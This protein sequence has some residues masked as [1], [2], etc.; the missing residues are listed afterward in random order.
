MAT[1][2]GGA[3]PAL[4]QGGARPYRGLFGGGVG[5]TEQSLV[6]TA[7]MGA[8]YDTDVLAATLNRQQPQG[9][10]SAG[11]LAQGGAGLNYLLARDRYQM[12]ST[13]VTSGQ[14]SPEMSSPLRTYSGSLGGSVRLLDKPS[15]TADSTLRYQPY[16][17][18]GAIA[19]TEQPF[20]GQSA[21]LDTSTVVGSEH[22]LTYLGGLALSQPL[23]RRVTFSSSYQYRQ[24]YR[25]DNEFAS[26]GVSAQVNVRVSRDVSLFGGYRANQGR[27]ASGRTYWNHQPTIGADMGKALSL[28]RRTT[29]SFGVGSTAVNNAGD[30]SVRATGSASLAHDVG[31]TWRL[32]ANYSR[33]LRYV[34]TFDEPLFSDFA[35]VGFGGLVNQR[36][37]VFASA[38]AARGEG[39]ASQGSYNTLSGTAGMIV[40]L[41]RYSSFNVTYTR[42]R[43]DFDERIQIPEGASNEYERHGIRASVG[44]WMPL[45]TQRRR[46]NA[47]R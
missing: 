1:T 19:D 31:R 34:E 24:S 17:F 14:Y 46:S 25:Q 4:A 33:G 47:S 27:Y 8:G 42:Y 40:G 7:S 20:V 10:G 28:T 26:Q 36:V 30:T 21:P 9:S 2:L 12:G 45:A 15:L 18:L 16:T 29:I 32:T 37:Q 23:S 5:D 38:G 41:S 13:A 39:V 11:W 22:Y 44:F 35:G 43:Y 6:A 3:S